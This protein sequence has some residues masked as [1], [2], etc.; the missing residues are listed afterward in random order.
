MKTKSLLYI[1]LSVLIFAFA[2]CSD[3]DKNE[4]NYVK[5]DELPE[6]VQAFLNEYLPNIKFVSAIKHYNEG[7]IYAVTLDGDI[8]V[9]HSKDDWASVLCK[10]GL[11]ESVKNLLSNESHTQLNDMHAGTKVVGLVKSTI[12]GSILV[13]L[14]NNKMLTDMFSHEGH[15]LGEILTNEQVRGLP[16]KLHLFLKDILNI[17]TRSSPVSTGFQMVRFSGFK[18]TIYRLRITPTSSM[19]FYEDGEWFFMKEAGS[20]GIIKNVLMKAIPDDIKAAL[21]RERPNAIASTEY[22]TRFNNNVLYGFTLAD[23]SFVLID[24]QNKIVYPPLDKAKEYIK[25]GFGIE[26]GLEYKV[27]PNSSKPYFLRYG[28]VATGKT[29][30]ISLATDV[31]GNILNVSAGPITTEVGKTI[32]LPRGLVEMLH[33]NIVGYLDEYYPEDNII[34]IYHSFPKI[35]DK[36][37]EVNLVMSI[38]NNLKTL[39]FD[40]NT[41]EFIKEYNVIGEIL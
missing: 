30:A 39:I 24:S 8:E 35:G 38:P 20:T 31:E 21:E 32:A 3:D 2:S 22:V 9:V 7:D 27:T 13:A 11:P 5:H 33:K 6:K 15:V 37:S 25:N 10:K 41:G 18:G 12:D 4:I 29:E 16:E 26:T 17:S 28:F 40:C 36:P 14:A 34:Q 1:L 23:K 19:D